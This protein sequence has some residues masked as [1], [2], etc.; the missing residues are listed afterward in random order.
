MST[1]GAEASRTAV[2]DVL[3]QLQ[4]DARHG[5]SAV[6]VAERLQTHGPNEMAEGEEEPLWRKFLGKLKEPMIALLLASAG[7]SLL[8]G[9][10]DDA[11]SI[12]LAV[13]IVVTV[14]C[15]RHL[16]A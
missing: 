6:T 11:I 16:A 14:V 2:A 10:Y 13:I 12:S 15:R 3:A 8:T 9:Q 7:V 5:L 4:V 1:L